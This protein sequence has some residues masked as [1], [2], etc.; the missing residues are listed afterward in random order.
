MTN[1]CRFL[2]ILFVF[3]FLNLA[4]AGSKTLVAQDNDGD[5]FFAGVD[6]CDDTQWLYADNDG[7]GF[8]AGPLAGCGVPDNT[9]CDDALQT[10]SD[11]DGDGFGSGSF[12][13]CGGV[14]DN[15][16]CDDAQFLYA[17][18]DGDGFG[19]APVGCGILDN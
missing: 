9:D 16:D 3:C 12:V 8:G 19:G 5:G 13:A 18:N 17:D 15:T 11:I 7:D 6:D 14:P 1:S 10:W 2:R 4:L